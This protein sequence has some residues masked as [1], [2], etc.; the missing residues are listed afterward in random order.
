[1][2]NIKTRHRDD[3]KTHQELAAAKAL[4][5][6][7][8]CDSE[9]RDDRR[10]EAPACLM[11][12]LVRTEIPLRGIA[13][14]YGALVQLGRP[15]LLLALRRLTDGAMLGEPG[16]TLGLH[17]VVIRTRLPRDRLQRLHGVEARETVLHR[18]S[19]EVIRQISGAALRLDG[20]TIRG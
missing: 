9:I 5:R 15:D 17:P 14:N 19:P 2:T 18:C 20:L 10:G 4:L 13:G 6:S 8:R 16:D 7:I 3:T 1:M 11:M 12:T